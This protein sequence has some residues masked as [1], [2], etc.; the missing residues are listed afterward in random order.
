MVHGRVHGAVLRLALALLLLQLHLL[1]LHFRRIRHKRTVIPVAAHERV[2]KFGDV[3]WRS[4]NSLAGHASRLLL[5]LNVRLEK[6]FKSDRRSRSELFVN[7]PRH[8]EVVLKPFTLFLR[9]MTSKGK[10]FIFCRRSTSYRGYLCSDHWYFRHNLLRFWKRLGERHPPRRRRLRHRSSLGRSQDRRRKGRICS[11]ID[12]IE[13]MLLEV[14][15]LLNIFFITRR[16]TMR[17]EKGIKLV[18]LKILG[19]NC[20]SEHI[21]VALSSPCHHATTGKAGIE[22]RRKAPEA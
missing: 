22:T 16:K 13:E 9:E 10:L 19:L 15:L 21:V 17:L 2:A 12:L 7:L 4:L 1:S 3:V 6:G 20:V 11:S 14:L 5:F 18:L 8:F